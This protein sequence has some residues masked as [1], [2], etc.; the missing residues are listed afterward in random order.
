MAY[1]ITYLSEFLTSG[2]I[3]GLEAHVIISELR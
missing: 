3:E 1:R 2:F